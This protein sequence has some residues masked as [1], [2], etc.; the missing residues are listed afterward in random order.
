MFDEI[1]NQAKQTFK[2][3][4][5]RLYRR[6]NRAPLPRSL[7]VEITDD[8]NLCC[9]MCPRR[10]AEVTSESM[11]L[12]KFKYVLD[13]L[14]KARKITLLGRGETLMAPDF[15]EML[16]WGSSRNISFIIVTNGT[17]LHEKNIRELNGVSRVAVSIDSPYPEKYK[18]IRGANLEAIISNLKKLKQTKKEIYLCIQALIMEDNVEDLSEFITLAQNAHADEVTLIHLIAFDQRLD[19]K[20]GDNFK[21][22]DANLQKAKALAERS[23]I[24]LAATPLY[25]KPRLCIDPWNSPR[26]S[27]H[28][29]IYP[30][31]YIYETSGPA[32]QEWYRGVCLN[33]PQ[34]QYKMGN[35]FEESFERIWNGSG[36]RVLR[37][38]VRKS[39]TRSLL[40]FGE[41]IKRRGEVDLEKKFSYCKVC[42]YRQ[43]RAC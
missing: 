38:A 16:N 19:E 42:L 23:G 9:P 30:C 35:I 26:V 3:G 7:S 14:P 18:K 6:S 1:W 2:Y 17:L 32:W 31:C 5:F 39:E 29:D 37:E 11:P 12:E 10:F 22:I 13:Q 4:L 28:G 20:H 34:H 25:Q 41:I 15:F 33:V 40:P 8:C 36:Y 21:D 27:L 24:K 43:N